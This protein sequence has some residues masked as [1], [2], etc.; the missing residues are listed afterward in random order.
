M[1]DVQAFI[2]VVLIWKTRIDADLS[3][4]W[5][6]AHLMVDFFVFRSGDVLWFSVQLM[7]IG[8]CLAATLS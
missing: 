1:E 3:R 8:P 6:P 7:T 2:V 5:C 4:P